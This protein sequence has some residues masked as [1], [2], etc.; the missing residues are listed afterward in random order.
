MKRSALLALFLVLVL[1][2]PH[3]QAEAEDS[4]PMAGANPQRT[5]WTPEEVR[6]RMHPEWAVNIEPFIPFAVQAIAAYDTI[7]LSTAKGLYALDSETGRLRWVFPT[8]M[9]LGHSPTVADSVVYVGGYDHRLYALNAYTG[10]LIWS[11]EAEGGFATNPLVVQ[12][13]VILGSRDGYLYAVNTDGTLAWRFHTDGPILLSAAYKDGVIYFASNDSHAYAVYTNGAQKW[14]SA[15]L[16]GG[17]FYSYWPVVYTKDEHN[18]VVLGGSN[19][20]RATGEL[21]A[22]ALMNHLDKGGLYYDI[23][24]GELVG[25]TGAEPGDWAPGTVTIDNSRAIEYLQQHPSRRRVFVLDAATGE[26]HTFDSSGDENPEYAPITWFGTH[27]G[28]RYPAVVGGDGVLYQGNSYISTAYHPQ[29]GP[30][31]WKFGTQ[32]ISRVHE[33]TYGVVD[34]PLAVS[35]GGDLIYWGWLGG[36]RGMGAYDITKPYGNPDRSYVY[37]VSGSPSEPWLLTTHRCPTA[38]AQFAV[39]TAPYGEPLYY[40]A[41]GDIGAYNGHGN[42]NPPVPYNDKIYFHAMN[43]VF[44]LSAAPET[45]RITSLPTYGADPI[46][47]SIMK[48][49][50]R[51]K[52]TSEIRNIINAGH[53]RPGFAEGTL[54]TSVLCLEQNS[55]M[56]DYFHNPAETFTTLVDALPHLSTEMQQKVS[57][58]LQSEWLDYGDKVHV[59]WQTGAPRETYIIPPEIQ[60]RMADFRPRTS[61]PYSSWD[62]RYSLYGRWRYIEELGDHNLAEQVFG[63]IRDTVPIYP[64]EDD[65]EGEDWVPAYYLPYIKNAFIAGYLGYIEI[66]RMAGVAESELAPYGAELERLLAERANEFSIDQPEPSMRDNTLTVA[67]NFMY[68]TPALADYL[69]AEAYAEVLQALH[70]YNRIAPYWFVSKYDATS[71][72]GVIQ[73]LYDYSALFQAKALILQ[74]PFDELVKWIDVPAFE[75]GDLFYIRNL[76]AAIEAPYLFAKRVQP[77]FGYQGDTVVYTLEFRGEGT[78]TSLM[79][80]LPAGVGEPTD[81]EVQGTDIEP[82][83]HPD[84]HKLEWSGSPTDGQKI[85]I[86]YSTTIVTDQAELLVNSVELQHS[87]HGLRSAYATLFANPHT[88]YLPLTTRS[89]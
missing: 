81:L 67:R 30:S 27:G 85:T 37:G 32:H 70:T 15:K 72:E 65:P 87:G 80:A 19:D 38:G 66:G 82:K 40:L 21:G 71:N 14:K 44:A 60:A 86:R 31:G 74:E 76:I 77:S 7:Y 29:G 79:D 6:G 64:P 46:G 63:E 61:N 1:L 24:E 13:K 58:Y 55:Y 47:V 88:I 57:A 83:Y 2:L 49:D 73:P 28:N 43:T 52:L 22:G 51:Q 69:R 5:S 45:C 78:Y 9:P 36:I 23:P 12:G 59:G 8:E 50:L 53:L 10:Y 89:R 62:Y 84:K 26:E 35:A 20:Y 42:T 34:E 41:G 25:P 68:M 17:G 39:G 4:W 48:D 16:A 3:T 56:T 54:G 75:R 11:Y 18:Y 33:G